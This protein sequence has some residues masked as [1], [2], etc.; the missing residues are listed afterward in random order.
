MTSIRLSTCLFLMKQFR[1]CKN[2]NNC[3]TPKH[4]LVISSLFQISPLL[5]GSMAFLSAPPDTKFLVFSSQPLISFSH[6]IAITCFQLFRGFPTSSFLTVSI[7][8]P[9]S[10]YVLYPTSQPYKSGG[11][12]RLTEFTQKLLHYPKTFRCFFKRKYSLV[13]L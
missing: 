5:V 9:F 1:W 7:V 11:G 10:V 12:H 3:V 13:F 2:V 4:V 6:L 8:R